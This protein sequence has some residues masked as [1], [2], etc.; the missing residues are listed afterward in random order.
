MRPL[1]PLAISARSMA[2]ESPTG[3]AVVDGEIRWSWRE[4]DERADAVARSLLRVGVGPGARV[5]LLAVPSAVA[6][7][8][9]H[10]I[11]RVGAVAAPLGTGLTANELSAAAEVVDPYL[12]VHGPGLAAAAVALGRP[13]LALDDLTASDAAPEPGDVPTVDLAEPAVVVLTSGTTGRPKAAELSTAALIASADAWLAAL[14]PATGWLLSLGLGHVAGLGVVWRAALS[15]VPLVVLP[16]SDPAAVVQALGG[17]P[18]PSH[19]SLVPTTLARLLDAVADAPPPPTLRAVLLGGGTIPPELVS[20]AIAAGWPVV[21][22]YGLTEAGSGVTALPSS[23]A[24]RHPESAGRALPGIEIQIAEPDAAGVGEIL[25]LTP[26]RFTGYL[27]DLLGTSAVLSDAGWLATGD[28]GRFDPDGRLIVLDRRTDRIVRGGENISP[29][30]VEAVLLQHPAIADAAV[31]AR[32]DTTWGHI[33]V[34]V[35]VLRPG[36]SDPGDEVLARH[37]RSRLAAFKVPGAF[38]RLEALPRTA[39][40]KLRRAEL[41]SSLDHAGGAQPRV[42]HVE[43]PGGVRLA[44]RSVG[45]GPVPLLLL[46]GT[47][48]TAG[49]LSGLA[50]ILAGTGEFTVLAVDRRGSGGS[51]LADPSP[52]GIEIHVADVAA[53]LDAEQCRAAVLMGVSFGGVVALEAAA[54]MPGRTLAVIA[55]EPPYGPLADADTQ[56]AFAVLA[57]AT[58]RAHR[59]GGAP[60]AAE[61]FMRGVAGVGAWDRFPERTR[62]FLAS[63]GDGAYVDAG[64]QGLDPSGLDRISVPVTLLTGGASESFYRPIAEALVRRIPGSRH[65]HLPGLAHAAPITDPATIADAVRAALSATEESQP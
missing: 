30:E 33:P 43:R 47:L 24:A 46:H 32:R 27:D 62:A 15:G 19:V 54:R 25:V 38:V 45:D 35:I 18:A 10:G 59:T 12:V 53:V 49:Q 5:A 22:T 23:E 6:I 42:R 37:C 50:R 1:P 48:S 29:A 8:V 41:R 28:L 61:A 57:A 14:P 21:P 34:A 31:V 3:P 39:G 60:S 26:A 2:A 20:R 65:L 17:D 9:L 55:Y 52:L 63:E 11:A 64:L 56:R 58:E 40:G 44:Y 36:S 13:M 7:A 4:L 51:R 16:R